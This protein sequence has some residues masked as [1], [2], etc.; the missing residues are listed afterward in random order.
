MSQ[1]P[2]EANVEV[3]LYFIADESGK[4]NADE[5]ASVAKSQSPRQF[6]TFIFTHFGKHIK[7]EAIQIRKYSK[8]FDRYI[9]VKVSH[10]D[11]LEDGAIFEVHEKKTVNGIDKSTIYFRASI[12]IPPPLIKD[13][14]GDV[15]ESLPNSPVSKR[16]CKLNTSA[17]NPVFKP[18]TIPKYASYE[19]NNVSTISPLSSIKFETVPS[20]KMNSV[21]APLNIQPAMSEK[22]AAKRSFKPPP[23]KSFFCRTVH[24]NKNFSLPEIQLNLTK[25][26]RRHS[27]YAKPVKQVPS[28]GKPQKIQNISPGSVCTNYQCP[29]EQDL[30]AIHYDKKNVLNMLD[31]LYGYANHGG[32][33]REECS[34]SSRP[35]TCGTPVDTVVEARNMEQSAN[36]TPKVA[37]TDHFSPARHN[38]HPLMATE[39]SASD[40]DPVVQMLNKCRYERS[41]TKHIEYV[42]RIISMFKN[43]GL[44]IATEIKTNF[45]ERIHMQRDR[46][47]SR[48]DIDFADHFEDLWSYG[49]LLYSQRS[50]N[51]VIFK[52][53]SFLGQFDLRNID[54]ESR[55]FKALQMIGACCTA[56][57]VTVIDKLVTNIM[58]PEELE[59]HKI[60]TKR[61]GTKIISCGDDYTIVTCGSSIP[62]VGGLSN[63]IALCI[64]MHSYFALPFSSDCEDLLLIMCVLMGLPL[65]SS[66]D[67]TE[68]QTD[69]VLGAFDI[70]HKTKG[71]VSA[72]KMREWKW[73]PGLVF[74]HVSQGVQSES[75]SPSPCESS[76]SCLSPSLQSS[77]G[78]SLS[79]Q[80]SAAK[81]VPHSM[82]YFAQNGNLEDH[83]L[84][85]PIRKM[86]ENR[87]R[88]NQVN[89]YNTTTF[90]SRPKSYGFGFPKWRATDSRM[91]E[92][93]MQRLSDIERIAEIDKQQF[94]LNQK[95]HNNTQ[96][97]WKPQPLQLEAHQ[98]QRWY[99][100]NQIRSAV[101]YESVGNTRIARQLFENGGI[102]T[103]DIRRT[104]YY[105]PSSN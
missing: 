5:T 68:K 66:R 25:H 98:R 16:P 19:K 86:W 85:Q 80:V 89:S 62:L 2:S 100:P 99:D 26:K 13:G 7:S 8:K 83:S 81:H 50:T 44:D 75:T 70:I 72:E 77:P 69:F 52:N 48:Y 14:P 103:L 15:A 53:Y 64:L 21:T 90:N 47:T 101:S 24:V 40:K 20:V 54:T 36:I 35:L 82:P 105:P 37:V 67:L 1:V 92:H 4:Q 38:P 95:A 22:Q 41:Y 91:P 34:N 94:R 65:P 58:R 63:A 93:R 96:M 45:Q 18:E 59:S 17:A 102:Q 84:V 6:A 32:D 12:T 73:I 71:L 29:P 3:L 57:N 56:G 79:S 61:G 33:K 43:A 49:I 27:S 88:E 23:P 42:S 46:T 78:H 97:H 87:I 39:Q 11:F 104:Y 10:L 28:N 55:C 31:E 60:A 51:P 9:T 76:S 74:N 30:S